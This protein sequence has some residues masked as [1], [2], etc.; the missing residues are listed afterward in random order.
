MKKLLEIL[1][2][3][4]ITSCG[5][6]NF[7]YLVISPVFVFSFL[8]DKDNRLHKALLILI[9]DS[10][11]ASGPDNGI[12]AA[13]PDLIFLVP[14]YLLIAVTLLGTVAVFLNFFIN[15]P[16]VIAGFYMETLFEYLFIDLKKTLKFLAVIFLPVAYTVFY[17]FTAPGIFAYDVMQGMILA[18][19]S[20]TGV[21]VMLFAVAIFREK[22]GEGDRFYLLH[23]IFGIYLGFIL[24]LAALVM[25]AGPYLAYYHLET[26]KWRIAAFHV[27]L[28]YAVYSN[29][30]FYGS[31]FSG[32]MKEWNRLEETDES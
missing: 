4:F 20:H 18:C 6:I 29:F 24:M 14:L 1:R 30:R 5:L 31:N 27:I 12:V 15:I 26:D 11:T 8:T 22:P 16:A 19:V 10:L 32:I 3:A 9:R 2:I 7:V 28:I 17:Y 25:F 13:S 21:V 23:R